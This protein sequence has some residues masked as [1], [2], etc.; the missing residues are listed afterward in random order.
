[1]LRQY[2]LVERVKAY[3]PDA[4]EDL[5]NRA[6]VFSVKA[7]GSQLRASGDP[8]FSHPV[9]VAG[10]LTD[11]KLDDKT[12]ATAILHDTIEDTV[13]TQE[14]IERLFGP[15]VARLVDG[16]TKLS[17]I[18]T[19]TESERQAENLRKFLL[20]MST[21]IRVLL[22][23]LADRLHNMRTL[24][25]IG[26]EEK[27]RRIAR[28]TMDIYAP[29]AER[30]GMYGFMEEMQELAFSHLEPDASQMISQ[31]MARLRDTTGANVHRIT[32][33]LVNLLTSK[34]IAATV[35]GREKRPYSIW[36]KM[37]ARQMSFE[38][39]SDVM[40]F[41]VILDDESDCYRALGVVH[42]RWPMV[43]G[44][45][46]DFISTPKANGYR[47]L[48]TSVLVGGEAARIE[49]QIRTRLMH[50]EAEYGVA[51]HWAYKQG[52]D[53]APAREAYPW[54]DDLLDVLQ[55]AASPEELLEN[56]RLAMFQD[57]VFVFTPKGELYQLPGGSTPVDFAY[58]V[59][60]NLGD[61]CVGAKVNGRAVPLRTRLVN[62]DQVEILKGKVKSPDPAWEAFVASA[63][64]R[65][66]IRRHVRHKRREE[67]LAMGA[68]L[69]DAVAGR[70]KVTLNDEIMGPALGRL[71]LHDRAALQLA[72]AE[73]RL[74]DD[75]VAE[76]LVPG[77]S[78]RPSRPRGAKAKAAASISI[79]GLTPGVGF[80]LCDH[81]RPVP[82]D[83]IVGIRHPDG[84][85]SVHVIDCDHLADES[86]EWLDVKW[87]AETAGAAARIAVVVHNQPGALAS[88]AASI[89]AHNANIVGLALKHRDREFHTDIVDI[90]VESVS[91]LATILGALRQ[92]KAVVSAD[93]VRL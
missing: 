66:A 70:L 78:T 27:R 42:G 55:D 49:V 10:I 63:K 2:E 92:V 54:I 35:T 28:E 8:Y 75:Q 24:H 40:A 79:E 7:H 77:A 57:Q 41:R 91:H 44:R 50:E 43:P 46:K 47:S 86:G 67:L 19:Q 81:C 64:A 72:M 83:R 89:A 4:D 56:A 15:D 48:H 22:V 34:G 93:R 18:E 73:N 29:L 14:Q 21:D 52:S 6:Y 71:K 51:A 17:K 1:M 84:P 60:S 3:D 13:A 62:G 65:A 87:G 74:S 39:L 76:A 36:R 37:A 85:I 53:G 69:L 25:H 11:L 45:F 59:H 26:K 31:R 80:L 20:A 58:A 30:I 32:S 82:G 9:E 33:A 12:I 68:K 61:S 23:K 16:V 5:L 88:L 90:E 38:Q